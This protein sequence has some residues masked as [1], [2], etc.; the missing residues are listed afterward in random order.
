MDIKFD[1]HNGEAFYQDKME[2]IIKE[3][4]E[5]HLLVEDQGAK[6]VML[7]EYNMPPC[8]ILKKDGATLYAT[9]DI[10]AAQYRI[11][12]YNVCYTKLLRQVAVVCR[13]V[14]RRRP[15]CRQRQ[16]DWQALAAQRPQAV[17]AQRF[18][19]H[20]QCRRF[21]AQH[22]NRHPQ[23]NVAAQTGDPVFLV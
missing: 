22:Q 16:L 20:H 12:S 9:R 5:K 19:R 21:R 15:P 7:D 4:E 10:A 17:I 1:S 8:M 23:A 13:N 14:Q 6:V 11:T 3:L 2:P 18:H